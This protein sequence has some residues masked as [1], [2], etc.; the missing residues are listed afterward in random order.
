MKHIVLIPMVLAFFACN[1]SKKSTERKPGTSSL[2][3]IL[4]SSEN[5]GKEEAS[6]LIV[7][8]QND[9]TALYE[10]V[11]N[12]DVPKVDFS[13]NQVVALFLGSRNTGGYSIS[14]DRVEEQDNQI[15]V[16][17]KEVTPSGMVTMAFTNPFVIVEIHSTKAVV[18]K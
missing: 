6:H 8:N 4:Y 1:S 14:I 17:K 5:Q 12:T 16:Y 13:T 9:L 7:N 15:S 3:S 11:G 2:Y 18:V 10:S